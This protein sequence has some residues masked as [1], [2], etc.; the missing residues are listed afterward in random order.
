MDY[1]SRN[2]TKEDG[3]Y[4]RYVDD[5]KV[6]TTPTGDVWLEVSK[7]VF[8]AELPTDMIAI[9]EQFYPSLSPIK[10]LRGVFPPSSI[11]KDE[12]NV[13]FKTGIYEK[14]MKNGEIE[15]Y[16]RTKKTSDYEFEMFYSL[17]SDDN[18]FSKNPYISKEI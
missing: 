10:T 16:T 3:K 7:D 11:A 15:G 9:I 18:V 17:A 12:D 14:R 8:D 6:Q 1:T 4:Y 5:V 13:C 2:I